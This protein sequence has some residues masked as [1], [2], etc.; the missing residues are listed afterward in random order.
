MRSRFAAVVTGLVMAAL[1]VLLYSSA[2]AGATINV[3]TTADELNADSDCSLR[4]AVQAAN[5]D[6][7]VDGCTAGTGADTVVLPAGIYVL[8]RIGANEGA[9]AS[10]DLD[11][12]SDITIEGAG[13]ATTVIDGNGTDR[14][15]KPAQRVLAGHSRGHHCQRRPREWFGLRRRNSKYR[16]R[17]RGLRQRDPR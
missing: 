2:A 5:T 15:L 13:A 3:N 6:A 8:T 11:V 4:E 16:R 7:A 14:V 17:A 9:N 1:M 12:L 10:G